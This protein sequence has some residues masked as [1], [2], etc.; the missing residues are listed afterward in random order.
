VVAKLLGLVRPDVAVFGRK[1]FQQA[2]LI[3][4]MVLDL[5]LG[6]R[7]ETGP[8]V[9]EPDGVA[10][11]SRNAYLGQQERAQAVGL[12]RALQGAALAFEEGERDSS[13]ILG[14]V[15][16]SLADYSLLELQYA[17]VVDPTDLSAVK[18]AEVGTV[19]A[20]AAFCGT[21]RLIDNVELGR[22]A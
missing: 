15:R 9:R 19:V 22:N 11:S 7:V 21:T 13:A 10:M 16:G 17:E 18:V 2:V 4:R 5:E 3:T 14:V 6:V 1:D 20:L 8:I 12:S